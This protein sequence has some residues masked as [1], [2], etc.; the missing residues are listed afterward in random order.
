MWGRLGIRLRG[1]CVST[2]RVLFGEARLES[3]K[4]SYFPRAV[5]KENFISQISD[6]QIGTDEQ[7][8]GGRRCR[9]I[10]ITLKIPERG[11]FGPHQ[12]ER[13]CSLWQGLGAV[14]AAHGTRLAPSVRGV[15]PLSNTLCAVRDGANLVPMVG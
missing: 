6:S 8:C 9:N 13:G 3:E 10:P 12:T 2:S 1:C 5:A 15:R 7:L 11:A 14:R 4:L